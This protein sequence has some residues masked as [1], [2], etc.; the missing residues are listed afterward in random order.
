VANV[1]KDVRIVNLSL[2]QTDWYILQLKNHMKVPIDLADDEI[3]WIK[4]RLPDG[5]KAERPAKPFY[6]ELLGKQRY[7]V[8]YYDNQNKKVVGL[9]N[10]MIQIILLSNQW[11]YPIYF[12]TTVSPELRLGLENHLIGEGFAYRVVQEKSQMAVNKELTHQK[13]WEVYKYRGFGD[14]NV[15]KDE[16]TVGVLFLYPEKFIELA[17]YYFKDNQTEKGMAEIKKGIQ[18][19]PDYYRPY[20]I[21]AQMYRSQGNPEEEKKILNQGVSR[22]EKLVRK[23]PKIVSYRQYLGILYN[24]TGRNAEAER[25]LWSAYQDDPTNSLSYQGLVGLY[26]STQQYPKAINLLE[27]WIQTNPSDQVALRTLEQ[28]RSMK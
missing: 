1:R 15:R 20:L 27:K 8:P 28:L 9:H 4:V 7:L 22:V 26:I 24:Q 5:R 16:N 6:D 23:Y 11:K 14:I 25:A 18:I 2:L 13:Y 17:S 3:K 12:S 10:Q 19:Y 21:L